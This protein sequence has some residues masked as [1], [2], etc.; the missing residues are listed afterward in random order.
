MA[1]YFPDS[2][3]MFVIWIK[4]CNF[5]MELD[6]YFKLSRINNI[7]KVVTFL[8]TALFIILFYIRFIL[9]V[10]YDTFLSAHFF[11]FSDYLKV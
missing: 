7:L 2:P 9:R 10:V 11:S 6:D 1:G 4:V 8:H 3:C 5:D